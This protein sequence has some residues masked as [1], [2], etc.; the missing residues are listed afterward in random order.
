MKAKVLFRASLSEENEKNEVEE[1]FEVV[2]SR[3]GLSDTLVVARYSCLPFYKE[4]EDDLFLQGSR[5]INS[6]KQHKYIA[7]FEYY[8]DLEEMT[9]RTWFRLIDSMGY[10]GPYV[11]KGRTNSRKH[12]WNSHMYAETYQDAVSVMIKLNSDSLLASQDLVFREYVPLREFTKG[13]NGLPVTNEW[14]C[15]FLGEALLSHGFYWSD[16]AEYAEELSESGLDFARKAASIISKSANFFVIDIAERAD[17]EW[18]VIEVNDGQMSGLSLNPPET[19]YS[20]LKKEL[21]RL[22][23]I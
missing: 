5:L 3:V 13:I 10:G 23:N 8:Y 18:T 1:Y 7:D 12:L 20:N 4:L 6:H 16:Y 11:I 9:P 2:E 22:D 21:D 15:F 17:G 14:R 19:L